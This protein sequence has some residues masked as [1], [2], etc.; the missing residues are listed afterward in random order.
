MDGPGGTK[1]Y[2]SHHNYT[3]IIRNPQNKIWLFNNPKVITRLVS[4]DYVKQNTQ[5]IVG[6]NVT[7]NLNGNVIEENPQTDD[8]YGR[9]K[10]IY[11]LNKKYTVNMLNMIKD[12]NFFIPLLLNKG[13]YNI[14]QLN[15]IL[16]GLEKELIEK[17]M[18]DLTKLASN[19][20]LLGYD[21]KFILTKEPNPLN[22]AFKL[23]KYLNYFI[24]ILLKEGINEK[25]KEG[26]N[27]KT[28]EGIY[29]KTKEGINK[30]IHIL[31]NSYYKYI[32]DN[33]IPDFLD[34]LFI[35]NPYNLNVFLNWNEI[36]QIL[37]INNETLLSLI[38]IANSPKSYE[39]E[40]EDEKNFYYLKQSNQTP[41]LSQINNKLQKYKTIFKK[42]DKAYKKLE[43]IIEN[44]TL[45]KN[46]WKSES[47]PNLSA[48][49]LRPVE[50]KKKID[51]LT[52]IPNIPDE[53]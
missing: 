17:I 37:D 1:I 14:D 4:R 11:M 7:R 52:A 3:E 27:E 19:D 33:N 6:N 26:I 20:D 46:P 38:R 40:D 34:Y 18:S 36:K 8:G 24:F 48:W 51:V 50:V 2:I 22:I 42:T 25:T 32:K 28:K 13:Y 47:P 5:N 23:S 31:S 43:E 49:K 9:T 12:N 15:K 53:D 29:E 39:D 10:C 21:K 30:I 41:S 35:P 16:L 44:Y 45:Y